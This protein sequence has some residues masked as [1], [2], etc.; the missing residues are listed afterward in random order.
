MEDNPRLADLV[1][2]V[3]GK[4]NPT[5]AE[6]GAAVAS[7]LAPTD[8]STPKLG[9]LVGWWTTFLNSTRTTDPDPRAVALRDQIVL[10][11]VEYMQAGYATGVL[12]RPTSDD[13]TGAVPLPRQ[14]TTFPGVDRPVEP[15]GQHRT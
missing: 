8:E 6:I 11:T 1:Q 9:S 13:E 5:P 15:V 2:G 14:E 3:L 7:V 10:D 4:P 12:P